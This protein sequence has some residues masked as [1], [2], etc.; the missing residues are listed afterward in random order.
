M[1]PIT[2]SPPGYPRPHALTPAPPHPRRLNQG[3]S[4]AP[5]AAER[6]AA[7]VGARVAVGEGAPFAVVRAAHALASASKLNRSGVPMGRLLH[8]TST[9]SV[10]PLNVVGALISR[11]CHPS[12]S[13]A[14]SGDW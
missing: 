10:A 13:S 8:R 3:I 7:L 2:V 9:R 1:T 14:Y 12:N 11:R 4:L 5:F 6:V